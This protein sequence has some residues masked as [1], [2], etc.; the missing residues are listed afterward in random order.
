[1]T[2]HSV[3]PRS[4]AESSGLKP[5]DLIIAV[6]GTPIEGETV[7]QVALRI[8]GPARNRC[9]LDDQAGRG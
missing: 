1:M 9:G 6:D 4:P 3:F 7:E 8:R 5:G 2:I